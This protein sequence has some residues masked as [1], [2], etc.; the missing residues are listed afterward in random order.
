[1]SFQD[2]EDTTIP[3]R[4]LPNVLVEKI[5]NLTEFNEL[6][7][8]EV[9]EELSKIFSLIPVRAFPEQKNKEKA[10]IKCGW[11]K[12]CTEKDEFNALDYIRNNAGVACGPASGVIVL[13]IDHVEYFE[14]YLSENNISED[15][16]NTLTIET[17][18][19][20]NHYYY[21]YPTD[22]FVYRKHQ[23]KKNVE[24]I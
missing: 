16:K 23:E 9:F 5:N 20:K 12:A 2:E 8:I 21:Q 14:E 17:G 3:V 1:M 10:P 4:Q 22:G 24:I 7:R 11:S 18:S 15:F 13:D 19:G 6:D